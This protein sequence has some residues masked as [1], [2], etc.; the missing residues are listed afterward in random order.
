MTCEALLKLLGTGLVPHAAAAE[1]VEQD[2]DDL[3]FGVGFTQLSSCRQTPRDPWPGITDLRKWVGATIREADGRL[4]GRVSSGF[5][6]LVDYL[7]CFGRFFCG[8]PC[9]YVRLLS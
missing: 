8:A 7:W 6:F 3:S 9:C 2:V 5:F 1:I 4:G